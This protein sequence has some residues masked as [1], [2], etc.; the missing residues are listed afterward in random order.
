MFRYLVVRCLSFGLGLLFIYTISL[1]SFEVSYNNALFALG[2]SFFLLYGIRPS[3]ILKIF[4]INP[5]EDVIE[6][7]KKDLKIAI[8][9]W[10]SKKDK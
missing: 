6:E 3:L 8:E 1:S 9:S 2:S 7:T 10:R 4:K 5:D